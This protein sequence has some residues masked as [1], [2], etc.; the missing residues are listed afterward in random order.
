[1]LI[2]TGYGKDGL[3]EL[4]EKQIT[5]LPLTVVNSHYHP[6]HSAGNR[7]FGEAHICEA[8]MP[9]GTASD[10]Q[11][12][13]N[14]INSG[15][16]VLGKI[17]SAAFKP[18]SNNDCKYIPMSDTDIFELGG[19]SVTVHA[20]PGH[21]KGSVMFTDDKTAA[22]FTNDSCNSSTWLFT[23]FDQSLSDFAERTAALSEKFNDIKK[24][25]YSH[26]NLT[27]DTGFFTEYGKFLRTVSLAD[28]KKIK[29]RGLESRICIASRK[30][31]GYGR[32]SIMFLESQI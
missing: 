12:L 2:D 7:I 18:M 10:S 5:A 9:T 13:I 17:I 1:M 30:L 8:D 23:N 6:D 21:T 26:V 24:V 16:P 28:S 15:S 27:T 14:K 3:K 25:Y 32:A 11:I 29:L 31:P 4:I 20:F 19:R 22:L